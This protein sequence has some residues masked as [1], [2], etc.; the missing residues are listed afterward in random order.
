MY[1]VYHGAQCGLDL[2]FVMMVSYKHETIL[3]SEVLF[4]VICLWILQSH[5]VQAKFK[6]LT[7]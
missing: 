1:V 6:V 5:D 4:D 3:T 2:V 7:V